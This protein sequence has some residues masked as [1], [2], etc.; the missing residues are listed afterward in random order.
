MMFV[1]YVFKIRI[2]AYCLKESV[3]LYL[4]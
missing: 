3:Y 1:T 4:Q 2:L